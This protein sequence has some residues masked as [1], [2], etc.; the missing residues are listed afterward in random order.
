MKRAASKVRKMRKSK[1]RSRSASKKMRKSKSRSRSGSKKMRKASKSRSRSGSRT[2]NFPKFR[3]A[4]LA[5]IKAEHPNASGK[6][7]MSLVRKAYYGRTPSKSPVKRVRKAKRSASKMKKAKK[8]KRVRRS[9]KK[10]EYQM[11]IKKY[12]SAKKA[13]M[14]GKAKATSVMKAL[15][16]D[17]HKGVRSY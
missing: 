4:N 16:A 2:R 10:S 9:S 12:F 17:W 7:L 3:A 13:A 11:F 8:T 14:G 6:E 15:A 1:S 5:K